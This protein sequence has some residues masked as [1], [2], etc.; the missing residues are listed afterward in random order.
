MTKDDYYFKQW[1]AGNG[2]LYRLVLAPQ[3]G[4]HDDPN[5]YYEFPDHLIHDEFKYKIKY[6]NYLP[7][8]VPLS[9]VAELTININGHGAE[10]ND[11]IQWLR[12]STKPLGAG[13]FGSAKMFRAPNIWKLQKYRYSNETEEYY[14][15]D[16]L[17]L[18]Q[19]YKP[20]ME[21]RATKNTDTIKI[22]LISIDRFMLENAPSVNNQVSL[23]LTGDEPISERYV[24]YVYQSDGTNCTHLYMGDA[25]NRLRLITKAYLE[26]KQWYALNWIYR[27]I[28]GTS[29]NN[30]NGSL[31]PFN[32]LTFYKQVYDKANTLGASLTDAELLLIHD[33][34]DAD[35]EHLAH[36]LTYDG[37]SELDSNGQ[38]VSSYFDYLQKVCD[39][40][41]AK[42]TF[43]HTRHEFYATK[44][45]AQLDDHTLTDAV[46]SEMT[47]TIGYK[48]INRAIITENDTGVKVSEYN[49][50]IS[51]EDADEM[52]ALITT[53]APA[54]DKVK[55]IASLGGGTGRHYITND[56]HTGRFFYKQPTWTYGIVKCHDVIKIDY[57]TGATY[58]PTPEP[59][60]SIVSEVVDIARYI[61]RAGRGDSLHALAK[62]KMKAFGNINQ[63]LLKIKTVVSDI[64]DGG[65]VPDVYLNANT[66]G[67]GYTLDLALLT[68]YQVSNKAILTGLDIDYITGLCDATFFIRGDEWV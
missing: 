48:G 33:I 66:F 63:A 34:V 21:I 46:K 40:T 1:R 51:T 45:F 36:G 26:S 14:W 62:M 52:S 31:D 68:K 15:D 37:L 8:G 19:D 53:F 23:D 2:I 47:L 49:G 6:Q 64:D 30:L 44:P 55:N 35:G 67:H 27:W 18:V 12:F 24:N 57:W 41:G 11:V 25:P 13:L 38:Q 7:Y 5:E 16:E 32:T 42:I 60:P 9:G 3:G 59:L 58:T 43:N 17:L 4:Q 56:L 50:G 39:Y 54:P 22:T 61:D 10:W 65:N 29:I 20:A 28:M